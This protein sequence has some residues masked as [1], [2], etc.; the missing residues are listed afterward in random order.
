VPDL[1]H[2]KRAVGQR[3]TLEGLDRFQQEQNG[4][5]VDRQRFGRISAPARALLAPFEEGVAIGVEQ[6]T[7][8]RGQP[9]R[10]MIDTTIHA[11]KQG[12]QPRPGGS[13]TLKDLL[14]I[15]A[16][17]HS[18]AGDGVE[19]VVAGIAEQEQGTF[20]GR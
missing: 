4:A 10:R 14:G 16:Q 20:L 18:Q 12:E 7:T 13:A 9:Q 11:T 6:R 8:E 19:G 15:R 17:L 5:I 1:L 2:V 3:A